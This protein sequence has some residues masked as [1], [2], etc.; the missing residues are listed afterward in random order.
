MISTIRTRLVFR[1]LLLGFVVGCSTNRPAADR[2]S[3]AEITNTGSDTVLRL[4]V[5]GDS[6]VASYPP[7]RPVYG[8]GQVLPEFFSNKVKIINRARGGR[9]SGSFLREGLWDRALAEKPDYVLI[10]FGHNDCPG[11]GERYSDPD[12]T[13]QDHLR[14]YIS[15][16]RAAG[17]T[18]ILVTPMTRRRFTVD[19]G[20]KTILRPYADAMI[21]VGEQEGVAVI[22]LHARSV[23]LFERLGEVGSTD[24]SADDGRDRTH[25]SA[26]GARTMARLI[27]EG[28]PEGPLRNQVKKI[29]Q[30]M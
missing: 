26:K 7:D 20:I 4:V 11:K 24:L 6:T 23:E 16:S 22:D 18:P 15:D 13:F 14:R 19:G 17:A 2:H 29:H 28:L 12:S 9:S 25:F 1:V 27:V 8:W 10:Q 5:V 3:P 30:G 21:R